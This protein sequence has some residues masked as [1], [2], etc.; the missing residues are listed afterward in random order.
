M[1]CFNIVFI[2]EPKLLSYGDFKHFLQDNFQNEQRKTLHDSG[3]SFDDF[4]HIFK[5]KLNVPPKRDSRLE[6]IISSILIKR[7][8]IMK[9]SRFQRIANKT[10]DPF[11]IRNGKNQRNYV[12]NINKKTKFDSNGNESFWLICKPYLTNS[13]SEADTNITLSKNGGLVLNNN[14]IE[15]ILGPQLTVQ[16]YVIG[17]IITCLYLKVLIWLTLT[18]NAIKI[19]LGYSVCNFHSQLISTKNVS[20]VIR[21]LKNN[22]SIDGEISIRKLK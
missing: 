2:T 12:V 13:R 22:K 4:D 17:L 9:R 15:T 6:E 8:A 7:Q 14:E 3:N 19:T 18:P 11:D 10:K 21:E 20:K 5:T 1:Q 16:V